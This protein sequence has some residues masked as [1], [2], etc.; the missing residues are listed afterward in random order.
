METHLDQVEEEHLDWIEMLA[1][2]YGPFRESLDEAMERL[3]HAKAETKPAPKE[4]RC[5]KCGSDLVYRFGKN[6]RFLSCSRYPECDFAA[7]VDREGRPRKA[8]YVDVRC[9]KTGRPMVRRTG[10]FG[11][12]LATMLEQ[13]EDQSVGMILNIDKKGHVVAPSPPPVL[14]ELPCEKCG[15]PLNLRNGVRGP[16]LGC[17]GFPKCR[18]R[19]KWADLP[20]AKR[21]DLERQLDEHERANPIPIITT[22]SGK[23][24]T[25]ARGKPL[26]SAPT[27]DALV[28]SDRKPAGNV[29]YSEDGEALESVA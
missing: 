25:D 13:G 11:P 5:A 16:W 19:G 23:P 28:I 14:T 4:Y 15:K 10:R 12:F 8:E 2:F 29:A 27:V 9:P 26:P 17:S 7:P 21:A 3:G 22:L 6:G 20:E 1:Q 18:G 24:L